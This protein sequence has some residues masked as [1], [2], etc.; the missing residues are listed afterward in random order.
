MSAPHNPLPPRTLAQPSGQCLH[1]RRVLQHSCDGGTT[2]EACVPMALWRRR[3]IAPVSV[4]TSWK[5]SWPPPR[6]AGSGQRPM[7]A[8]RGPCGRAFKALGR[9]WRDAWD[10]P[11]GT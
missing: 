3:N 7:S 8:G 11:S 5:S 2:G 1:P 6:L 9:A 10:C 4:T